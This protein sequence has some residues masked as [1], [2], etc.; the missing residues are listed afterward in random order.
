V[1]RNSSARSQQRGEPA[2]EPPTL[3]PRR[4]E[5]AMSNVERAALIAGRVM[6]G[7]FFI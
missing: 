5:S 2:V 6:F 3:T 7:G 1:F 4:N